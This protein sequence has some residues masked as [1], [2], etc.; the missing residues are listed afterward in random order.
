MA[1]RQARWRLWASCDGAWKNKHARTGRAGRKA[2]GR[3]LYGGG[4]R[5]RKRTSLGS[6]TQRSL[7]CTALSHLCLPYLP[8][9]ALKQLYY[10]RCNANAPRLFASLAPR[11]FIRAASAS[12]AS[13]IF[14]YKQRKIARKT[15]A[16]SIAPHYTLLSR[17]T[18]VC[19]RAHS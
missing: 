9:P 15:R 3:G 12:R 2:K 14:I 8:T 17:L 6:A 11:L 10:N 13:H 5:Q 19:Y 1:R 4:G 7:A 16:C 18:R